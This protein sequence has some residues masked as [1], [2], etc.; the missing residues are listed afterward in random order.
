MSIKVNYQNPKIGL[1][2]VDS[3]TKRTMEIVDIIEG[4]AN[5][6]YLC[7][8]SD[9]GATYLRVFGDFDEIFCYE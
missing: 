7:L 9:D 1:R 3:Y 8:D 6:W 4:Q 5:T 2:V